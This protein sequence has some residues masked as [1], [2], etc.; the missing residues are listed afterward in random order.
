V[1]QPNSSVTAAVGAVGGNLKSAHSLAGPGETVPGTNHRLER[2]NQ[3]MICRFM[4]CSLL[5]AALWILPTAYGGFILIGPCDA[6]ISDDF[7][8]SSQGVRFEQS[9]MG[10]AAR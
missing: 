10:A 4:T 5:F 7:N 3:P 2:M 8:S 1:G 6:A 9:I